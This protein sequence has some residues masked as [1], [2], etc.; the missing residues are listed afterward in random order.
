MAAGTTV[1][2]INTIVTASTKQFDAA[3]GKAETRAGKFAAAAH[4]QL[5]V[6][7][8]HRRLPVCPD[9]RLVERADGSL[10]ATPGPHLQART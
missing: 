4:L 6:P 7:S 2:R 8:G 9:R 5:F 10:Y 1:A 3:M